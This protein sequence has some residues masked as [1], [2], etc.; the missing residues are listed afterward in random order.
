MQ[1]KIHHEQT[2]NILNQDRISM[3]EGKELGPQ[4]IDHQP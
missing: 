1:K 2:N 3:G 4:T